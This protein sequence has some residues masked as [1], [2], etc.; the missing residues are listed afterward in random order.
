MKKKVAI[1]ILNYNGLH[2][3][4]K[5]L[6]AALNQKYDDFEVVVVDNAST[7]GSLD[8][9][10]SFNNKIRLVVNE[11][12][13]GYSSGKNIG[14]DVAQG[15]YIFSLD[16]DVLLN[17][18]ATLNYLVS[19]I[20][21]IDE[22]SIISL[23]MVNEGESE[24]KYYSYCYGFFGPVYNRSINVLRITKGLFLSGA[25]MG[26]NMFFAKKTWNLIGGFDSTQPYYLDDFDL[27]AR[28]SVLGCASYVSTMHFL[29]H[30]GVDQAS[31]IEKWLWKYKY[32]FSGYSIVML[33]NYNLH[34][35]L[36][37]YPLFILF[38]LLKTF[39]YCLKY[40]NLK[41]VK[42]LFWSTKF[43]LGN[44]HNVIKARNIIQSRRTTPKDLFLDISPP[45]FKKT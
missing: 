33:K 32:F 2:Y 21:K 28:A 44:I 37:R 14:V 12:N 43:L 35:L 13:L 23:A 3:L 42:S 20:R 27:G 39:K 29:P 26:G 25:P 17:S 40:R 18:D 5:T 36:F 41:P 1:V 7:D 4:R 16:N 6:P 9:L 24:T 45:T 8:F 30:L 19:E 34:N 22:S 11:V 15:D 31:N 10:K 38:T